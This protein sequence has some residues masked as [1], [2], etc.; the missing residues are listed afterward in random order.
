MRFVRKR[1]VIA[2]AAAAALFA[3]AGV[4]YATIPDG[5]GII[6]G[7]YAKSGGS[8]R[9][10]DAGV[11]DCKSTETSLNWSVQGPAGPQGP[12]GPA[13]SQGPAGPQGPAGT[14]GP[15]GPQGPSGSSHGYLASTDQAP[16]AETPAYS[17]VA[18]RTSLPD[19]SYMVWAQIALGDSSNLDDAVICHL[20]VNGATV[21]H[22]QTHVALKDGEGNVTIVSAASLSGGGS[23][24]EVDCTSGD[25]T[26]LADTN[27]A[28]IRTDAL[29]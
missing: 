21:P 6:H 24:V 25:T 15:A 8:L 23:S 16:I 14:Q 17:Q 20:A 2:A 3:V 7:G 5:T 10:I 22:T 1:N 28:L 9:V 29:N 27:L 18:L 13:G 4:A 12:Q 11:V 19:G 26:A